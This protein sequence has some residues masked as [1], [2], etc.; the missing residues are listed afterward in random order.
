MSLHSIGS[1]SR[2]ILPASLDQVPEA[3][4]S[5]R[6]AKPIPC[7]LQ[8][9]NIPSLSGTQNLGGSS[10]LQIPCGAS[11][12][13]M[14][15]PYIRFTVQFSSAAAV[16]NSSFFF[17]G[18]AKAATSCINRISSYVNSVQIDNQQNAWSLY[19]QLLLHST[20]NDWLTHDGTL[21]LGAGVQYYQPAAGSTS[22]Q[23]YTFCAPLLGLL[24]SQQNFPLYLVNGTLQLQLDWNSSVYGCYTAGGNDPVWTGASFSNVQLVFD[25]IQPEQ[26]FVDKVRSDMMG[27]HKYVYGY[28]NYQTTFLNVGSG[29]ATNNLNYGLNVSSLRGVLTSQYA[30]ARLS[31]S[32]DAL[33]ISNNMSNFQLSVDGRLINTVV[34]DSV[35]TPALVFAELQKTMGRVFDASISDTVVNTATAAQASAQG[36]SSGGNFLTNAFAVG[37]STQR[38][39]EGLSF[40]GSPCSIANI[41]VI[42]NATTNNITSVASTLYVMFISDFQLLIDASG[43]VEIVR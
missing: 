43:S 17:K 40:S 15:N 32:G 24:G 12:G 41:Q 9:V 36:N 11:A 18:G 39:N 1:D 25:R 21:M 16:A 26:A 4:R 7:S 22:S 29:G 13:I 28:T 35:N 34:L 31:D 23:A 3:F 5:N 19:D 6:M 30:T 8:T 10:V 37:V 33:P 2:Y 20:S 38:V 27:G 14:M 42:T